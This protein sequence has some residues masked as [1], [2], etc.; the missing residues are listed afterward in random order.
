M[1]SSFYQILGGIL[2]FV[3]SLVGEEMSLAKKR[4]YYAIF[5]V[6]AVLYSGIGI[7]LD[8]HASSE[9][10]KLQQSVTSL[11]AVIGK[12]EEARENERDAAEKARQS[13]RDAFLGQ[14]NVLGNQLSVV[15]ANVQSE[16]LR[17]QLDDTQRSLHQT[18]QALEKREVR[19]NF[20]VNGQVAPSEVKL[21]RTPLPG[22]SDSRFVLSFALSNNSDE[23]AGAGLADISILCTDCGYRFAG[24]DPWPH[25]DAVGR[26]V[27]KDF[28]E[29]QKHSG[30]NLGRIMIFSDLPSPPKQIR[31]GLRYQCL[32]CVPEESHFV[33]VDLMD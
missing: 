4:R 27:G 22:F 28:L 17:K 30:I 31:I 32:H 29:I 24:V 2:I 13:D 9:Q 21:K 19:L 33:L 7:L 8:R 15:R 6:L 16:G 25:W 20:S 14:L 18:Q 23:D 10:T 26:R 3:S 11:Q 1:Y 5:G 12:S